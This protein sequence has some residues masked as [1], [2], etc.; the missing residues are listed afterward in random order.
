M[1]QYRQTESQKPALAQMAIADHSGQGTENQR[2]S[3]GRHSSPPIAL[4]PV[5]DQSDTENGQN[6]S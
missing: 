4:R 2:P 5:T 6:S 3:D 1:G